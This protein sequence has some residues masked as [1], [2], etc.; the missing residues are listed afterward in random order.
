M[1]TRAEF[2]IDW[3]LEHLEFCGETDAVP[4]AAFLSAWRNAISVI[5][6]G[7]GKWAEGTE[8][9]AALFDLVT[10]AAACADAGRTLPS[11]AAFRRA[12]VPI[13]AVATAHGLELPEIPAVT[14]EAPSAHAPS[15]AHSLSGHTDAL[16]TVDIDDFVG[17]VT[18]VGDM[19]E[20]DGRADG[21]KSEEDYTFIWQWDD[22][23]RTLWSGTRGGS[24]YSVVELTDFDPPTVVL[25]TAG[26]TVGFYMDAM[27]WVDPPHRGKGLSVDLVRGGI[28]LSGNV[29]DLNLVGFSAAGL[30][31]HE[32]AHRESVKEAILRGDL[33]DSH[34]PSLP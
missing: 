18:F 8:C 11:E 24:E 4:Y 22:F 5:E 2:E 1:E 34:I 10:K 30:A 23:G 17:G 29:P 9:A 19:H 20:F 33:D 13:L 3:A 32:A 31:A 6:G 25:R 7:W 21:T 27:C 16:W 26:E 14:A 12:L 28:A 15:E